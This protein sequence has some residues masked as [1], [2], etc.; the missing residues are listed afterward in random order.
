MRMSVPGTFLVANAGALVASV[1]DIVKTGTD[2]GRMDRAILTGAMVSWRRVM[3][4]AM[5][6]WRRA[7][8]TGVMVLWRRAV[9]SSSSTL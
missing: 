7:I 2:Q 1:H 3:T 9:R 6:L 4:G 5:A 8:L